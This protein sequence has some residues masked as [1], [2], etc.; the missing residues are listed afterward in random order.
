VKKRTTFLLLSLCC[1]FALFWQLGSYGLTEPDEGRTAGIG[2]EFHES[3]TWLVPRLY[4]LAQF[5]KPPLVYW[6]CSL[7]YRIGGVSELTARLPAALAALGVLMLTF[8]MARRLYGEDAAIASTLILL[9][10]PMF[11]VMARIIDPNMMLTFWITLTM[12]AALA[13]FQ[14]ARKYQQ[15][16]FWIALG[17]AFLAKGPPALGVVAIALIGFRICSRRVLSPLS[18]APEGAVASLQWRPLL[19]IP[20]IIACVAV[21]LSWYVAC[22]VKYPELWKFFLGQEL[23]GRLSGTIAGRAQPV[24]YFVP[25][26]LGGFLPWIPLLIA[27]LS[28]AAGR[29]RKD[30]RAMF[31]L[32]WVVLPFL[33]FSLTKSKLPAYILPLFPP[34]AVLAGARAAACLEKRWFSVGQMPLA[35]L[36]GPLV[37][38]GLIAAG[39]FEFGWDQA[40]A[41]LDLLSQGTWLGCWVVAFVIFWLRRRRVRFFASIAMLITGYVASIGILARHENEIQAHSSPKR[42]CEALSAAVKPGDRVVIYRNYPRGVSF[43]LHHPLS[44]SDK[45]EPQIESDWSRLANQLYRED[46]LGIVY[47]WVDHEPRVFV[48]TSDRPRGGVAGKDKSPLDFL[49]MGCRKPLQEIYR[50][51]KY[52]VV[53]NFPPS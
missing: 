46:D 42:M 51:D 10:A 45:Y 3:G 4:D 44:F 31:L 13:W 47:R 33:M 30:S 37:V 29:F 19:N 20:A 12:W 24:W 34:L 15:W 32:L 50:D 38:F 9:T 36:A 48:I 21:G 2:Y 52:V 26:L 39:R 25:M 35:F 27:S 16:L 17:V 40:G 53:R 6:A 22:A 43:Y 28:D 7:A 8:S 1:L 14:D 11:F 49:R 18:E 41:A 23:V 5:N